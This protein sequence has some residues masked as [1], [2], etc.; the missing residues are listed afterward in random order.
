MS[1]QIIPVL[2]LVITKKAFW[3]NLLLTDDIDALF[4][5]PQG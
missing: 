5:L 4:V 2:A 1:I 3:Y